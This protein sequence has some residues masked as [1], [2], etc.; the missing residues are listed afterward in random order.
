MPSTA[1]QAPSEPA[2][3]GGDNGLSPGRPHCPT[4]GGLKPSPP[5]DSFSIDPKGS[6][7]A[8]QAEAPFV[9]REEPPEGG[10]I[11][12]GQS[13]R[14]GRLPADQARPEAIGFSRWNYSHVLAMVTRWPG[15]VLAEDSR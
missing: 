15:S 8:L 3:H 13:S 7:S 6:S 10:G 12:Q 4:V 1:P 11:A 5:G 2:G 9:V 14:S